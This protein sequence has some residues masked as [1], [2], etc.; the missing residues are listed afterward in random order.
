MS[1]E[2]AFLV[3]QIEEDDGTIQWICEFPDLKGCIGVGNTYDEAVSE[4]MLNKEVW[5]ETAKEVGREIPEPTSF[6]NRGYSG[7]FN[8][9]IPKSLHRDLAFQAEREGVSLNSLCSSILAKGLSHRC[10]P[11]ALDFTYSPPALHSEVKENDWNK[12]HEKILQ[13]SQCA[14]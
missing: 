11:L 8:L 12:S 10:V 2:H 3:H 5:I 1:M 14:S 7:K 9:R 4:G 6:D 13:L